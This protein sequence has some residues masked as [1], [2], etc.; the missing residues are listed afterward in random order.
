M[1]R[2]VSRIAAAAIVLNMTAVVDTPFKVMA[3]AEELTVTPGAPILDA[4]LMGWNSFDSFYDASDLNETN[5]KAIADYMAANMKDSGYVYINLDGGWW[6]NQGGS[7]IVLVDNAGRPIP[8]NVRF[9]SSDADADGDGKK[10]GLKP[11]ADYIHSKGLK[12]GIYA[13]RGIPRAANNTTVQIDNE[14][15]EAVAAATGQEVSRLTGAQ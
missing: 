2:V 11:L 13:T 1:K 4:P 15:I 5:I 7:G 6:N 3:Q 9:P 12:L 10:D 8:G 14:A